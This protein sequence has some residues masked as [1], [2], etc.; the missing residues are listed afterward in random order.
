MNARITTPEMTR[1][2]ALAFVLLAELAL[3]TIIVAQGQPLTIFVTA[4][5]S[6][7]GFITA[8]SKLRIQSAAE[9]AKA[10]R[11]RE[12]QIMRSAGDAAVLI[13]LTERSERAATQGTIFVPI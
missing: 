7:D 9:L 8:D 12:I 11:S 13:E 1:T 5:A 10:L 3:P 4:P 2:P 6:A